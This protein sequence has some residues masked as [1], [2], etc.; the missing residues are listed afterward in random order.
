MNLSESID[1]ARKDC[2]QISKENEKVKIE[3]QKLSQENETLK[4]K[5]E[6]EFETF[7]KENV[8]NPRR[9]FLIFF[10][11]KLA[12]HTQLAYDNLIA[13]NEELTCL[14]DSLQGIRPSWTYLK[15][16][17]IHILIVFSFKVIFKEIMEP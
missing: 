8:F 11:L 12:K 1:R 5:N 3:S 7:I 14:F 4:I 17:L 10:N 15:L 9:N 16:Y 13:A 6:E 2:D